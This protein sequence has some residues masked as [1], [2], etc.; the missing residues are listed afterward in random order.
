MRVNP[1]EVQGRWVELTDRAAFLLEGP[2]AA[3]YLNGQ[4]TNE[5]SRVSETRS[6]PACLCNLKGRAEFLVWIAAKDGAL[7]IDG[8]LSQRE[9]LRQR[10]DRYLI[11]DDCELRD[12]TGTLRLVHHFAEAMPGPESP[13]L[14]A[15][16]VGR[17]LW[18]EAE[19][20]LALPPELDPA[21]ELSPED[22]AMLQLRSLVPR[23]P[24]EIDGGAFPAELRLDRWAVD[25][26]KGCYLGQEVVSRIESVGRVNR[27]LFLVSDLE[28]FDCDARLSLSG[29]L[30]AVPTRP[31]SEGPKKIFVAPAWVKLPRDEG[32]PSCYQQVIQ[33]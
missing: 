7:L 6:I 24:E 11:A 3:R 15:G 12:A 26:H 27:A 31:S 25:F 5:V 2:D 19:G 17:D 33:I 14:G 9:D 22:F 4:V 8:Q 18:L 28:P 16:P 21:L 13:R 30:K 20:D 10:L 29:G 32:Q 23:A 1:D